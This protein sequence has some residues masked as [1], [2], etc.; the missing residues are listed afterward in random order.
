MV[1]IGEQ[2]IASPEPI[3]SRYGFRRGH[4]Q[5]NCQILHGSFHG[6]LGNG[7]GC[8]GEGLLAPRLPEPGVGLRCVP[9]IFLMGLAAASLL[10]DSCGKRGV[11]SESFPV[12]P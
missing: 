2:A 6:R 1:A 3:L 10:G 8:L 4:E 11:G 9:G 7:S 12:I 5:M